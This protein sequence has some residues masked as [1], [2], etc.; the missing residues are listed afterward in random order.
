LAIPLF[1]RTFAQIRQNNNIM[2]KLLLMMAFIA[3]L[4][5][6]EAQSWIVTNH[7]HEGIARYNSYEYYLQG[8]GSVTFFDGEL[9]LLLINS[10]QESSFAIRPCTVMGIGK[11]GAYVTAELYDQCDN[12]TETIDIWCWH[13]SYLNDA[14]E[15]RSSKGKVR[16]LIAHLKAG[17]K[18][19]LFAERS[20]HFPHDFYYFLPPIPTGR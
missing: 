2:K 15:T 11:K 19:R 1:F 12:L 6:A 9:S 4:A 18:I 5:R 20:R 7:D 10:I 17:N 13:N 3:C 8:I 14:I 16:R